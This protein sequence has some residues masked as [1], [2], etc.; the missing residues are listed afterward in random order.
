MKYMRGED[1]LAPVEQIFPVFGRIASPLD[2]GRTARIKVEPGS[3]FRSAQTSDPCGDHLPLPYIAPGIPMTSV[4]PARDI[5]VRGV[6]LRSKDPGLADG[7]NQHQ[8]R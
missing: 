2:L 1:G 6:P 5:R 4:L 7:G 8:L 3:L